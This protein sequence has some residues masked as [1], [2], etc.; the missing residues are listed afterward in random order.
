M[1][2]PSEA[3]TMTCIAPRSDRIQTL[4]LPGQP[5]RGR[6]GGSA[7]QE[8]RVGCGSR[9]NE[10]LRVLHLRGISTGIARHWRRRLLGGLW[11]LH[12]ALLISLRRWR[13][14]GLRGVLHLLIG[15]LAALAD[16]HGV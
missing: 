4:Y 3:R 1:G 8:A 15:R 5:R 11:L 10:H 9:A 14:R 6:S 7:A 12:A 16:A 2:S 13:G